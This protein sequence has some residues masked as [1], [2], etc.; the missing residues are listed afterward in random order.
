MTVSAM[1]RSAELRRSMSI[2]HGR[3]GQA[4]DRGRDAGSTADLSAAQ[5]L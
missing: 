1:L 5:G 2:R 3:A 4:G